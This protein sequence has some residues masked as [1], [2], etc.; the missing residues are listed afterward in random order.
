MEEAVKG[1][2]SKEE[3]VALTQLVEIHGARKWSV[4]AAGMKGRSGKSCRLRWCNQL[5]PQ[6]R[7]V[8]FTAEEERRIIL[9]HAA[10]GNRW[11]V[12]AATLPGRTDNAV[13]NHWNSALKRRYPALLADI[14][15]LQEKRRK[16]EEA[17]KQQT[18]DNINVT[19][20]NTIRGSGN[21]SE[22]R[23]DQQQREFISMPEN[24][25]NCAT[26]KPQSRC[27][28]S[29]M[30]KID[31]S[32]FSQL[33]GKDQAQEVTKTLDVKL[34][35]TN[36]IPNSNFSPNKTT[37]TY[38]NSSSPAL[39]FLKRSGSTT[40]TT[41]FSE[42]KG[43][44]DLGLEVFNVGEGGFNDS[45]ETDKMDDFEKNRDFKRVKF[46]G[47]KEWGGIGGG[48]SESMAV[49]NLKFQ[50]QS[51]IPAYLLNSATH[52][53]K[54]E[55]YNGEES[56]GRADNEEREK[57]RMDVDSMM[58]TYSSSSSLT[59]SDLFQ[60]P[61]L[62]DVSVNFCEEQKMVENDDRSLF[63]R[64]RAVEMMRKIQT[65][66]A[67]SY[68][69]TPVEQQQQALRQNMLSNGPKL[70]LDATENLNSISNSNP[71]QKHS[72][73]SD[74]VRVT[75]SDVK[76]LSNN[77]SLLAFLVSDWPQLKKKD[78]QVPTEGDK[79][80]V[81][82]EQGKQEGGDKGG[83]ERQESCSQLSTLEA[84]RKLI[85]NRISTRRMASSN[86]IVLPT[87]LPPLKLYPIHDKNNKKRTALRPMTSPGVP[88]PGTEISSISPTTTNL[89]QQRADKVFSI[90][91]EEGFD[92]IA[93]ACESDWSEYIQ[94]GGEEEESLAQFCPKSPLPFL[95]EEPENTFFGGLVSPRTADAWGF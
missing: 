15:Q 92:S 22:T 33:E 26:A 62:D 86:H 63:L 18:I 36:T 19:P 46:S 75:N 79:Q 67:K 47:E 8:P 3:D 68:F 69:P 76:N 81:K 41:T 14:K 90:C 37:P 83:E 24:R 38:K 40:S 2:W 78:H 29:S 25:I 21:N 77:N 95:T 42:S 50:Y 43:D 73:V 84:T 57:N 1:P 80:Q 66:A 58:K 82:G 52:K 93:S 34:L 70:N 56:G 87:D 32:V 11:A 23:Q 6:V 88:S 72:G 44:G 48:S 49:G 28:D 9:G 27:L 85:T 10:H 59:T 53:M 39:H 61:A 4:I 7:K 91:C 55:V 71:D 20:S 17:L 12:I 16:D 35:N 60:L 45:N 13:K 74:G 65:S 89:Q 64:Q 94:G 30:E 54:S 5:D 51:L 31:T